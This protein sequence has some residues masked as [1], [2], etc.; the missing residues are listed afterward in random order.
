MVDEV[1]EAAA[2]LEALSRVKAGVDA[3]MESS[4]ER[5]ASRAP[6]LP[7]GR[8][9]RGEPDPP[10][11]VC[12]LA[13]AVCMGLCRWATGRIFLMGMGAASLARMSAS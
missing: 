1:L 4:F 6:T 2:E 8:L 12:I 11:G 10:R 5:L 7:R 9:K 13:C 3:A